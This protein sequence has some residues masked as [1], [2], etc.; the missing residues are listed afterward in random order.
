MSLL[1]YEAV[2]AELGIKLTKAHKDRLTEIELQREGPLAVT[3]PDIAEKLKIT[4]EQSAQI[5]AIQTQSRDAQRQTFQQSMQQVN[6]QF[7][8]ADGSFNRQA[9]QE[10]MQSPAGQEMMQQRQVV[11]EQSREQMIAAIGNVLTKKQKDA[12]KKLLGKPFDVAQLN[13]GPGG[14]GGG[15]GRNNGGPATKGAAA[16]KAADPDAGAYPAEDTPKKKSTT[17]AKKSTTKKTARAGG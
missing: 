5:Q 1:R 15:R 13:G 9:M 12:Y 17:P 8:N 4:P 10:F 14:P 16:T 11:A 3:R 2:Q 6:Q 7:Q